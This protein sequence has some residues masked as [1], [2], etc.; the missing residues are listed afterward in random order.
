MNEPSVPE[1]EPPAGKW[2]PRGLQGGRGYLLL[3][4]VFCA[5]VLA[6]NATMIAIAVVTWPG[7]ATADAYRKGMR[8][9]AAL[10]A[11]REQEALGWRADFAFTPLGERRGVVELRLVDSAGW[12]IEGAEVQAR[13][14]RPVLAGHDFTARLEPV[15]SGAYRLEADFPLAG[16]W[17][18]RLQAAAGP[19]R[20]Q[21][22]Q[23]V[24]VR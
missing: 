24:F 7:L 15:G 4:A 10:E 3:F 2:V 11:A 23:R 5:V 9:N 8:Y 22:T 13:L 17:D 16:A 6:A 1:R 12:P 20:Y 18:V 14:L 19:K 21:T